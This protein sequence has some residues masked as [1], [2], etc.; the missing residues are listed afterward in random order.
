MVMLFIDTSRPPRTGEVH[1]KHYYY[2]T[3][4]EMRQKI[5]TNQFIEYEE[6][7]GHYYGLMINT[8]RSVINQG[9]VALLTISPKVYVQVHV[10]VD[11]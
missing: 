9:K 4:E 11:R 2:T 7:G 6:H 5:R 1:G 8:V 10:L 3:R